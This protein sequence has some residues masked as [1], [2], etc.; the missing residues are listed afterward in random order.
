METNPQ[1][2]TLDKKSVRKKDARTWGWMFPLAVNLEL[3]GG[4]LY[5]VPQFG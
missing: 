3:V 2:Q 5:T 4:F 1:L